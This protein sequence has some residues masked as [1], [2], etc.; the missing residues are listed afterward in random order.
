[1]A[2]FG[3]ESQDIPD[4]S[5]DVLVA[6]PPLRSRKSRRIIMVAK[7]RKCQV[8]VAKV[9]T[10]LVLVWKVWTCQ[11][12]VAKVWVI[13][14]NLWAQV[15]DVRDIILMLIQQEHTVT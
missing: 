11:N 10:C 4:M 3:R 8:L 6:P 12:F 2:T 7:V 14:L 13:A 1:M 5:R 9:C 15:F